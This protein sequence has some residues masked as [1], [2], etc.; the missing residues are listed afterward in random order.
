MFLQRPAH[1]LRP[2]G[3]PEA[4]GLSSNTTV[5]DAICES[6]V[7]RADQSLRDD[8]AFVKAI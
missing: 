6:T 2:I 3:D 7:E 4:W 5:D 1:P 8:Q